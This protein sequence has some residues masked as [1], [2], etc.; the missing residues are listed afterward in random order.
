MDLPSNRSET[1]PVPMDFEDINDG[2]ISHPHPKFCHNKGKLSTPFASRL[3]H[4]LSGLESENHCPSL[5]ERWSDGHKLSLG[6]TSCT[7][8][9]GWY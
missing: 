4:L 3:F 7:K 8:L 1:A 6:D 2:T 5:S 9:G